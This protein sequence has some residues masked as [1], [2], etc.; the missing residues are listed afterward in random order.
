[1]VRKESS[2][3]TLNISFDFN[4]IDIYTQKSSMGRV[5]VL[6]VLRSIR[7]SFNSSF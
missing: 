5:W 1:M 2:H 7:Y 4:G 3:A 6:H